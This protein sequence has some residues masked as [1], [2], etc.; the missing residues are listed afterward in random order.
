MARAEVQFFSCEEEEVEIHGDILEAILLCVPLIDLVPTSSVSK[1]WCSIVA[2]SLCHLK[3]SKPWLVI[4]K[5]AN[6]SPYATT[7]YAY[8]PCSNQWIKISQP[9]I[10]FISALKSS[11]SIVLYILSSFKFSFSFDP[12]NSSWFNVD[13]PLVWRMDLIVARVGDSV[14][15]A[16]GVCQFEE[17]LHHRLWNHQ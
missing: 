6:R 8:D 13:P 10:K 15:V 17:P 12:L 9:S 2:S 1:S 14:M 5:Q 7:T 4:H 11:Q 3:K 16:G